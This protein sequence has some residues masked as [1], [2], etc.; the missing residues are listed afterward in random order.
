MFVV[1]VPA[2]TELIPVI[3]TSISTSNRIKLIFFIVLFFLVN[4]HTHAKKAG[5]HCCCSADRGSRI[6]CNPN[7]Q[8]YSPH[9]MYMYAQCVYGNTHCEHLRV[10]MFWGFIEFARFLSAKTKRLRRFF[11][12]MSPLFYAVGASGRGCCKPLRPQRYNIFLIY[13]NK[14]QKNRP[15][16]RFFVCTM[17]YVRCTIDVLLGFRDDL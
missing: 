5:L 7:N 1:D 16:E 3:S 2:N 17:Y 11:F 13:T 10:A 6:A 14:N 4:I 12:N 9:R 8:H 15:E